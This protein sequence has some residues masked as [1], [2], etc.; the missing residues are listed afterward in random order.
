ME[1]KTFMYRIAQ[2]IVDARQVFFVFFMLAAIFCLL[3]MGKVRVENDL[4]QYLPGDTETRQGMDIMDAAFETHGSARILLAN[5][6]FDRALGV[7]KGIEEIY[8]VDR[9]DFYDPDDDSYENEDRNDYY[10]DSS[11]LITV[12]FDEDEDTPLSQQAIAEV[13][14]YVKDYDNYVYT[15]VDLDESAELQKDIQFILVLVLATIVLVL[16]FT[17]TT[18]AEVPVFMITFIMA[19]ILN[20]G[21]N[22]VFGTIS[23]ISNAV[24]AVLQLA[25]AIDYAIIL[26]QRFNEEKNNGANPREA[27]VLALSKAIIEISSSSLTTM[28]GLIA[29]VFMHFKIGQDLGLVLCKAIIF[30]LLT[31]FL[32]MPNI[33]L[34]FNGA[35]EKT[36]H[37]SFVPSIAFWGRL[38]Y[39]FRF[40]FPIVFLIVAGYAAVYS[41]RCPYLFDQYSPRGPKKTPYLEAK[42]RINETFELTN[43][44]AI[45]LPRGDYEK[46]AAIIGELKKKDYVDNIMALADIEVGDNDEYVLTD[47]LNPR[48]FAEVADMDAGISKLLYIAYAQ[49]KEIYGAFVDGIDEYRVSVIDMIDFIYDKKEEGSL[50]LS[51]KQSRDVA[52]IHDD[53]LT[54]RKQLESDDYSRIIFGLVDPVEGE[55]TFSRVDEIREMAQSHYKQRIYVVGDSTSDYDLSSSFGEDNTLISVLTALFVGVI[56]LFTFSSVSLPFI[57]LLTIQG[58]IWINFSIPTLQQSPIFFLCYLIVSSIQMGATI[59]YAIVITNRYVTLRKELGNKKE[60]MVHSLDESFS[61]ILTSGSILT[62]SGFMIGRL[63]SNASISQLGNT[64]GR[65][66]LTSIILVLLVLPQL[67]CL[68]DFILDPTFFKKSEAAEGKPGESVQG[69]KGYVFVNGTVQGQ[70]NGYLFGE[71][72]GT[73]RGEYDLRLRRGTVNEIS[74]GSG[75]SAEELAED[76]A[77]YGNEPVQMG[78]SEAL[79]GEMVSSG[80]E[81]I[82]T[83]SS[84]ELPDGTVS[85][86]ELIQAETSESMENSNDESE[87]N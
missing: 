38:I 86:D 16:T 21:T 87:K 65:G 40:V 25:L 63:T 31:V 74:Q 43:P 42:D 76:P 60:A 14:E 55:V 2:I 57:L 45:V 18:F 19:A 78:T 20:K 58:S 27:M 24:D 10:R 13:R 28:A 7:S 47:E 41:A 34:M 68:F 15:T 44:M 9:V 62:A 30:S 52:D 69:G 37:R 46:E 3:H 56:L 82:Q 12:T 67:L 53:I 71:F 83:E 66:T 85:H 29:L 23:Y 4:S 51:A 6:T 81:S 48:E 17:S 39:P 22:Y 11:A 77:S 84:G 33:I 72:K 49:D 54:A 64:L 75:G 5:I 36:R 61:T 79:T 35:M 50:N 32:F 26:L 1:N 73:M 70:F 8:G 59:D 80:D